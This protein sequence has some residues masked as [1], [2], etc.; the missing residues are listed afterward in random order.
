MSEHLAQDHYIDSENKPLP[1]ELEPEQT[2]Q[3]SNSKVTGPAE[4]SAVSAPGEDILSPI[5][6]LEP[7]PVI[8]DVEAELAKINIEVE[9]APAL[10]EEVLQFEGAMT[11]PEPLVYT[12]DVAENTLITDDNS[13]LTVWLFQPH[14]T[15]RIIKLS[16]VAQLVTADENFIWLDLS[17]YSENKLREIAH[18]LAL[19]PL[20]VRATLASW[21]RPRYSNFRNQF[22]VT[23]TIAHLNPQLHRV[24]AGELDL[25]VGRNYLVSAHKIPLPFTKKIMERARQSPELVELDSA[26]MLY[27]ILDELLEYYEELSDHI[28]DENEKMEQRALNDTS[29]S[30]LTDL[31][32]HKSYI[33]A[34]S[35]LADQHRKVFAALLRPDSPLATNEEVQVYFQDLADH[36][37]RL[38][39]TLLPAKEAVIG[40]FDIYVSHVSHRTNQV[41]KTLTI[42]STIILPA[43]V[44]I[45]LFGTSITGLSQYGPLDF[46]LMLALIVITTATILLVFRRRG[47]I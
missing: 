46:L 4:S 20:A 5:T 29:D 47:W 34:L 6:T 44:I 18:I 36:F 30:F 45:S 16:E 25:F 7:T 39:D 22:F 21:Q 35:R 10:A 14:S 43:S 17:S 23:T 12:T 27:I 32:K 26:F 33:F 24:F 9:N 3:A 8:V 15:A 31:V 40:A 13:L 41:I 1:L 19:H 37:E 38:L 42:V 28:E 2:V 11:T